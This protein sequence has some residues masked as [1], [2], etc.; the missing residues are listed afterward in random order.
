MSF[1]TCRCSFIDTRAFWSCRLHFV[2]AWE[3]SN[4][5]GWHMSSYLTS[6]RVQIELSSE[7]R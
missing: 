3:N 1:P 7:W 6:N 2:L 4:L 5:Y